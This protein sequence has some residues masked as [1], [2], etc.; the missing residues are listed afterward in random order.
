[1]KT[2][3]E[4]NWKDGRKEEKNRRKAGRKDEKI[5]RSFGNGL[6]WACGGFGLGGMAGLTYNPIDNLDRQAGP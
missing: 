1:M 6:G 5:V 4:Q 2:T 3:N